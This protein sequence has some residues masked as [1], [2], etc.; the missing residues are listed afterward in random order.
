M[1]NYQ[2]YLVYDLWGPLLASAAGVLV[3]IGITYGYRLWQTKDLPP[4]E[5]SVKRAKSRARCAWTFVV[6]MFVQGVSTAN[7]HSYEKYQEKGYRQ[8]IARLP[9]SCMQNCRAASEGADPAMIQRFCTAQCQ[10]AMEMVDTPEN[11]TDII[12]AIDRSDKAEITRFLTERFGNI[13]DIC[14]ERT[15]KALGITD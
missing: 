13:A 10:C 2:Y 15:R 9:Q 11:K 8:F 3:V 4:E 14:V 5:R 6:I 7:E 12:R 1:T